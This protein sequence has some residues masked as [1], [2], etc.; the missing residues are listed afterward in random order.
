MASMD[1]GVKAVKKNKQ[2]T[3]IPIPIAAEETFDF[4]SVAKLPLWDEEGNMIPFD[5]LYK[6]HK[7]IVIFIRHFLCFISRDYVEDLAKIPESYLK[8]ANVRLVVIGCA[9][10]K[11]IK[12]YKEETKY[13]FEMY[14][15]IERDVYQTLGMKEIQEC[16]K[17]SKHLKHSLI[18]GILKSTW[19]AI[20]T[21]DFQG[22]VK[23]QG[24]SFILGKGEQ[25]HFMHRDKADQDHRPINQ[26]LAIAGVQQVSYPKDPRIFDV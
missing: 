24:G 16:G 9:P 2:D 1:R 7:V 23:Q 22:D 6:Q 15:D 25:V 18:G 8:D 17:G 5:Y 21:G 13:P 4:D 19:K 10:Y 20:K 11:F 14:C 26:L 12:Q 3:Y